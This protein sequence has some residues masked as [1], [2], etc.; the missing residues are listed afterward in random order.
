M[1][2]LFHRTT[3]LCQ[4]RRPIPKTAANDAKIELDKTQAERE[5]IYKIGKENG[6]IREEGK[7]PRDYLYLT[8]FTT[9][10]IP[11]HKYEEIVRENRCELYI[12]VGIND[13]PIIFNEYKN[14]VD[15][16]QLVPIVDAVYYA[17]IQKPRM[18]MI[19]SK[20]V[21]IGPR[22]KDI[23][24]RR[25][26][27]QWDINDEENI[28]KVDNINMTPLGSNHPELADRLVVTGIQAFDQKIRLVVANTD[29]FNISQVPI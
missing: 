26:L 16:V 25:S 24:F 3:E 7:Q 27:Y 17:T 15:P 13:L 12:R 4:V 9:P 29:K 2:T 11:N 23:I 28:N 21:Y 19:N 18:D 20:G 5:R 14:Y 1:R 10:P 8:D 6:V 22:P